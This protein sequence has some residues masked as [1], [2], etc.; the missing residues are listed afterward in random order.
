MSGQGT[1]GQRPDALALRAVTAGYGGITVL[2]DVDVTVPAGSVVALMGA[3]GAGKT[4]LLRTAAGLLRPSQ[5][6]VAI[7][8]AE[9]TRRQHFQRAR[10][11]LCLIPEGRGIF[12]NLSF[13]EN[14]LL[15]VP[16]WEKGR[17]ID[18]ALDAF[19]ILRDRLGQT[20]GT[21]SGGEQQML[22][23]S[24]CFLAAPR[25]VLLDEVSMGLAPRIV[26]EI[27]VALHKL[28]ASGVALLL[29]EQ[30]IGRALEMA[31]KI[32]LLN[33]G[34]VTFSGSPAELN[35]DELMRRYIGA[36]LHADHPASSDGAVPAQASRE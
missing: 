10:A 19:P 8:G 2:R 16:P 26:D 18:A 29:V 28:A 7:C 1:N 22:A 5:G 30:Y 21:M 24:R 6:E 35:A 11:G 13:R 23:L 31:D 36:D 33:R 14:L 27:F 12:P 34:T 3:N 20:A 15:Q 17:S 25:V 4:T 32:Y 9:V